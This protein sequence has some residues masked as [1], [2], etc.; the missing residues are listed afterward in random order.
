[1]LINTAKPESLA[2]NFA[3]YSK[4]KKCVSFEDGL[5]VIR[6]ANLRFDPSQNYPISQPTSKIESEKFIL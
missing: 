2:Y 1:M 4:D 3:I 6:E 5:K